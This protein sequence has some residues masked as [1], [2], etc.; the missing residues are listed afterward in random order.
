MAS[1]ERNVALC[2]IFTILTCGIYGMYWM[3]VLNDD[4]LDALREEGTS[5]IMVLV[6]SVVTC[7]I[8]GLYWLYQ[9]GNRVD[10]LNDSYRRRTDNSGLL[11]LI[12]GVLGFS[13]VAYGVMQNEM[14][15]YFRNV[16]PAY[17][18]E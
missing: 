3:V 5:G 10:R 18:Y 11:Y 1:R 13:I 12:L 9:M 4:M 17:P 7:G 16:P 2:I 8:Y 14:N 6:L 15:Q